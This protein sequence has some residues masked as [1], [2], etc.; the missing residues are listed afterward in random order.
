LRERKQAR[1]LL[2]EVYR[3]FPTD[4]ESRPPNDESH[5]E[6]LRGP[7][8]RDNSNSNNSNNNNSN[9]TASS[10]LPPPSQSPAPSQPPSPSRSPSPP[11]PCTPPPDSPHSVLTLRVRPDTPPPTPSLSPP[12][13]SPVQSPRPSS[14]TNS[15]SSVEFID[16][17][18]IPP[19]RPRHYYHYDPHQSIDTLIT[20]FPQDTDPL[21]SGAYTIG[22]DDFDLAEI[23]EIIATQ[24][25]DSLILIYLP[26]LSLQCSR[27]VFLQPLPPFHS[28]HKR[29]NRIIH[30]LRSLRTHS[31]VHTHSCTKYLIT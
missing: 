18:H 9:I 13:Y 26:T 31:H 20:Q 16:E 15:T 1:R 8:P 5:P 21:S 11:R 14:P 27:S 25:P 19:P 22:P 28:Y 24:D 3:G 2:G 17:I 7:T 10:P 12:S 29:I 4:V 23:R 6:N 30:P